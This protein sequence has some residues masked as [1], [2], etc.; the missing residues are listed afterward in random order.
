[1]GGRP[2]EGLPLLERA[3]ER[4]TTMRLVGGM[5]LLVGYHADAC[6]LA[7]R[8]EEAGVLA[9][10]A[11]TLAREHRER[12]YEAMALRV[13]GEAALARGDLASA[14]TALGEAATLAEALGMLPLLGHCRL[15]LGLLAR[16]Q[17]KENEARRSVTEA[18]A[19]YA[20]LGMAAWVSRAD[21]ELVV[22]G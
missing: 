17:G 22:P 9:A 10:R 16:R 6:R 14:S 15:G 19:G 1:M 4:A 11:T 2:A 12:G 7:G 3:V 20:A 13:A 18:R 5:A 8:L 21:A